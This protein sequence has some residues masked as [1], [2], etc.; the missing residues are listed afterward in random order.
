MSLPADEMW[1]KG[2]PATL[3]KNFRLREKT[4][5]LAGA[6]SIYALQLE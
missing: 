3:D 1:T 5:R 2:S 6:L 4:T